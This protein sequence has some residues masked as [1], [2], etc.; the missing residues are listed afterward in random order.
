M[1]LY[2]VACKNGVNVR[3]ITKTGSGWVADPTIFSFENPGIYCDAGDGFGG[4]QVAFVSDT[5]TSK[6]LSK[7]PGGVWQASGSIGFLSRINR[8]YIRGI[9]DV[10][11]VGREVA[12]ATQ[13]DSL[14]HWDG[15]TATRVLFLATDSTQNTSAIIALGG[16]GRGSSCVMMAMG[17]HSGNNLTYIC[18]GGNPRL[19]GSWALVP[20]PGSFIGPKSISVVSANEVYV[21]HNF[22]FWDPLVKKWDGAGWAFVG[23]RIMPG[24][25]GDV[26]YA[27]NAIG[28]GEFVVCALHP[29]GGNGF[30]RFNGIGYVLESGPSTDTAFTMVSE[31]PGEVVAGGR[32]GANNARVY[33]RLAGVW[34]SYD[35]GALSGLGGLETGY[36]VAL[37][38]APIIPS[39][40]TGED[41]GYK[42]TI[43]GVFPPDTPLEVFIGPNNDATDLPCYGGEGYGYLPQSHDGSTLI[44]VTPPLPIGANYLNWRVIGGPL[45]AWG[46]VGVVDRHWQ[47]KTYRMR[48]SFPPWAGL[49]SRGLE[50]EP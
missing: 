5:V 44:L 30:F 26:C 4:Y 12:G 50:G 39:F 11:F 18:N 1:P 29:A 3:I 8:C 31:V 37:Y 9:D 17:S 22:S 45:N 40:V 6:I 16:V 27:I 23:G 19:P 24:G 32:F 21:G 28:G 13:I 43:G 48:A 14:Y 7:Y 46:N 35:V 47:M 41:G 15:V 2:S 34:T 33:E 42:V 38:P 10:V 36:A 49:G 20:S 25:T